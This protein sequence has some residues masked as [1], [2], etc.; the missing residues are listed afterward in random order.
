MTLEALRERILRG[1]YPEGAPLRQDA[2]AAEFGVSR[3]P[4]REALRQLEAEGLVTINPHHGATVSALSIEEVRELFELRALIESDLLRRAVPHLTP[5]DLDRA[6]EILAKYEE[7]FRAGDVSEWGA[8]N[9]QFHSTLLTPA[10]RPLTMGVVESLQNQSDRYIRLQL[11]LTSA[12]TRANE[13][14]HAIADAVREGEVDRACALLAAHITGAG[15]SLLTFLREHR[16]S[17]S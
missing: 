11:S 15:R 1:D 7:A 6:D 3:I 12:Q 13:E 14:H 17:E 8:L 16:A 10:G 4:V 5:A 2:L 9:W